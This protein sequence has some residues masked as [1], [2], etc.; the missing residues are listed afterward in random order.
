MHPFKASAPQNPGRR[1]LLQMGAGATSLSALPFGSAFARQ[2]SNA[3]I[4]ILGAG[5]AGTAIA[6]RLNNS[7]SG[8]TITIAGARQQHLYQPGY[9]LVASGLWPAERVATTT[10][11]WLPSG[12]NWIPSDVSEFMPDQRKVKLTDGQTLDYDLRSEERRVGKECR[13]RR[14]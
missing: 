6:N 5:A 7:L 9:T 11:E 12:V 14:P 3:R 10:A 8:A 13:S 1:R 2:G 4:L